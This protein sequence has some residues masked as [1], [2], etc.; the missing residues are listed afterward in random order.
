[1]T[2]S[3]LH[4]RILIG[5]L[6]L[7]PLGLLAQTGCTN[8]WA[9]NYDAFA[10]EDD[11]SCDLDTCAGCTVEIACNYDPAATRDDGSCDFACITGCTYGGGCTII[12]NYD[13][14]VLIDDG[15]CAGTL[16]L[17]DLD[18]NCDGEHNTP[19][20]LQLLGVFGLSCSE[21]T[22]SQVPYD[23]EIREY[24]SMPLP[25][26]PGA[27]LEGF[28]DHPQACNYDPAASPGQPCDFHSCHGCGYNWACNYDPDF[29]GVYHWCSFDCTGCTYEI[30]TNYDP[31]ALIDDGSCEINTSNPCRED[32]DHSGSIDTSDLLGWMGAYG[33]TCP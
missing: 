2:L 18:L 7:A 25:I 5:L 29:S 8:P 1:M 12:D 3:P 4:I 22:T 16:P 19:D 13:P 33:T 15:T 11:G 28:C 10:L 14:N 6:T 21:Y 32:F 26:S 9:C 17:C 31:S 20:L 23:G 24:D 27:A 30:A